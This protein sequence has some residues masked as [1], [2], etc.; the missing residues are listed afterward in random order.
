[1]APM[2]NARRHP[3]A[4]RLLALLSAGGLAVAMAAACGG[5]G[6]DEAGT[7][8]TT[9]DEAT[10]TPSTTAP[11]TPE[12]EAKAVYLEM[13]DV[14]YRLLTSN[15]DGDDPDLQRVATEPLLGDLRESFTTMRA[16]NQVVE[17]GDRTAQQVLTVAIETPTSAT[18]KACSVGNDR[19][20]D[21]DDGSV[22]SEGSSASLVD[23]ALVRR[24]DGPW[25]VSDITTSEVF[26]GSLECPR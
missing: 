11:V 13:T 15:L 25:Q 9:S 20:I 8:P 14:V 12:D 21:Q 1:M 22:V 19:T 2:P 24:A 18:I 16:E 23:V 26:E 4:R 7:D 3:R 6:D 10:T 17:R 5:G